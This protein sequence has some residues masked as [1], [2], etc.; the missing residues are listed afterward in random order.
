MGVDISGRNPIIRGPQ[1]QINWATATE[2]EKE[3]Y[4]VANTAWQKENPGDY[5]RANWWSWRP[6]HALIE[7]LS[8][9]HGLDIDTSYYG[10]NDGAGLED[11]ESCDK[12]ADAI[13]ELLDNSTQLTEE[14]DRL[15]LCL[16]SWSSMDKSYVTSEMVE[17]LDE[18]LP[19]HGSILYRPFVASNGM[20]LTSAHSTS[21]RHLEEF[22]KFLRECGGFEIW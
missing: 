16:G 8:D 17:D 10:S 7:I 15:Y 1:P 18:E 3:E 2:T 6:I 20:I 11:K 4:W 14:N 12:L 19:E 21:K 5:F 9:K 13:Q 22:V